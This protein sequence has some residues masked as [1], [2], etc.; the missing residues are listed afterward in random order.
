MS[1]N[2][3]NSFQTPNFYVDQLMALL[4]PTEFLILM[5]ASRC[6][7]GWY[8]KIE[9]KKDAISLSQFEGGKKKKDGTP[10]DTGTGL[11]R[12]TL[13]RGIEVLCEANLLQKIGTPKGHQSQSYWLQV[14]PEDVDWQYLTSR[15]P[16]KFFQAENSSG[17]NSL[18]LNPSS[19]KNSL[20]LNPSSG[21]NSLPTETHNLNTDL[22]LNTESNLTGE[23]NFFQN[24]DSDNDD[25]PLTIKPEIDYLTEIQK[26]LKCASPLKKIKANSTQGENWDRIVVALADDD[27]GDFWEWCKELAASP[28]Q[29]QGIAY[30]MVSVLNQ[31]D[32]QA[33]LSTGKLPGQ[34]DESNN[35]AT[36]KRNQVLD[37]HG[38][39]IHSS[40][41]PDED[42]KLTPEMWQRIL[43]GEDINA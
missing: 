32:Y 5:Y 27:Q 36:S 8:D 30:F 7:L 2:V 40:Y 13:T 23:K 35:K 37:E 20:P 21:K 1:K 17:K 22:F 43:K 10:I 41:N 24:D 33:W 26:L 11:S 14:N 9:I 39:L 42:V 31:D 28:R 18:P 12:P 16:E 25:L 6:I 3:L 4:S 29:N 19:G 15:K 38:Q 34:Q